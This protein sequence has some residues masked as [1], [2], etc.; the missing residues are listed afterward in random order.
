MKN[1]GNG[2]NNNGVMKPII[3]WPGNG[4]LK[5]QRKASRWHGGE[6]IEENRRPAESI[7]CGGEIMK[8]AAISAK[9]AALAAWLIKKEREAAEA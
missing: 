6:A 3:M 4:G 1:N 5:A 8:A 7:A 2:N 9:M